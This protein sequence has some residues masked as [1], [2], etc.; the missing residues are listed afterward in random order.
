MPEK[1]KELWRRLA[2]RLMRTGRLEA[3]DLPSFEFMCMAYYFA[4]YAGAIL[5]KEGLMQKDKKH[6]NQ[7][8]KHPMCQVLR[9]YIDVWR[10]YACEFGMTPSSRARFE[11]PEARELTPME[12]LMEGDK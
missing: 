5:I 6:K 1:S 11:I 2:P 8:R 9:N 3:E 4:I 10:L 12:R 7:E